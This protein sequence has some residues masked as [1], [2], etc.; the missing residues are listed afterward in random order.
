MAPELSTESENKIIEAA[1]RVFVRKGRSGTSMQDIAD[2]VGIN[3]TSL[4]YYFRSKDKLFDVI[5]E[6]VFLRFI[7]D[8]SRLIETKTDIE[9]KI[10]AFIDVYSEMLEKSPL[11][12]TFIL[13]EINSNPERLLKNIKS[14]GINPEPF[15]AE[16][17]REMESGSIVKMNPRYLLI[18]LMSL[19]ILPYAARP[20]ITG[21]IFMDQESEYEEFI[22]YRKENL[23]EYFLQSIK[24]VK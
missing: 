7:P 19:L 22:R 17:E 21:I 2:E 12:P 8:I 3:R 20:V 16:L 23:K 10:S 9:T 13:H 1:T 15:F 6:R 18:N 11:T 24:T 5:F 4:N 14:R